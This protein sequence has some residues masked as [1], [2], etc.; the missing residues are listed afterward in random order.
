M[1][2]RH[3]VKI[4]ELSNLYKTT[5]LNKNIPVRGVENQSIKALLINRFQ[6]IIIFFEKQNGQ[7]LY[8]DLPPTKEKH[9]TTYVEKVRKTAMKIRKKILHCESLFSLWPAPA[10]EVRQSRVIECFLRNCFAMLTLLPESK[11][12]TCQLDRIS[13]LQ[14]QIEK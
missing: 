11:E 9:F 10:H 12:R 2:E 3:V 4:T 7:R 1:N 13:C 14:Q 6:E 5:Q 8:S